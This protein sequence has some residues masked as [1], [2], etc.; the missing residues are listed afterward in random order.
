LI[1]RITILKLNLFFL[2]HLDVMKTIKTIIA[3]LAIILFQNCS[4]EDDEIALRTDFTNEELE[5]ALVGK[6]ETAFEIPGYENV[7]FLEYKG[8][9]TATATLKNAGK[10]YSGPCTIEFVYVDPVYRAEA[11]LTISGQED[12]L[13]LDNL[14]FDYCRIIPYDSTIYLTISWPVSVLK[15]VEK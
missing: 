6:W 14:G 1:K 8:D 3:I 5:K 9:G 2:K 11:D 7:T 13:I 12:E 4:K 10:T 15:R